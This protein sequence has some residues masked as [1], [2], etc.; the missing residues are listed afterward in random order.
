MMFHSGR[1]RFY[2][3]SF[4]VQVPVWSGS[5]R[6]QKIFLIYSPQIQILAVIIGIFYAWTKETNENK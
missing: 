4:A 6:T 2:R 1:L 3:P 5:K